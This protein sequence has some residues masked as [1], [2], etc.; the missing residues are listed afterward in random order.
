MPEKRGSEDE[1]GGEDGFLFGLLG[2]TKADLTAKQLPLLRVI[3][4]DAQPNSKINGSRKIAIKDHDSFGVHGKNAFETSGQVGVSSRVKGLFLLNLV[5]I[6]CSSTFVVLK[7]GQKSIDPF[8]FSTLRF[9]LAALAFSPFLGKAMQQPKVHLPGLEV[10]FWAAGGYLTQS[11]SLLTTDASRGAFLSAFTVVVVPLL[12]GAFGSNKIKRAH[13]IAAV[14]SLVGVMLIEDSGTPASWGDFWSFA[15]AVLFGVQIFRTEHWSKRLGSNAFMP[16]ISISIAF[17]ALLSILGAIFTSPVELV[18]LFMR[19]FSNVSES[20]TLP[21]VEILYMAFFVTNFGL[22]A[23][24]IAL[25]YIN[26]TEAAIV[27]TLEPV[28]GAG[29][30]WL[31]LGEHFGG[32]VGWLGAILVTVSQLVSFVLPK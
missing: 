23:E 17:I 16:M 8:I 19:P 6:A 15:S 30:A 7:D 9:V 22:W 20:V 3:E 27:Y 28:L 4:L 25:Q 5:M 12:E 11:V 13:W 29:F 32:W 10:G 26:S 24:V 21:W 14:M 18:S 1:R 2:R 31:F